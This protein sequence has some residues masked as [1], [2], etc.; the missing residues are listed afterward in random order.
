MAVGGRAMLSIVW[1]A[2]TVLGGAGG[3][4]VAGPAGG[5]RRR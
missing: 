5:S 1:V 4:V 3:A 2:G